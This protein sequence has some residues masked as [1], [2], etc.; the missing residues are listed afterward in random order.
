LQA[1]SRLQPA[2]QLKYSQMTQPSHIIRLQ[3]ITI[4]WMLLECGIALTASW[5]ARS[6]VLLAFG[7]DSFVEL[8]SAGVV[9]LQFSP[10]FRLNVARAAWWSG[11]LL[12]LLAGLVTGTSLAALVFGVQPGTSWSGIAITSAALIV[13]PLL[14]RAKRRAAYAINNRALAADA[15]QSA[16]CA[17][18]AAI[19]LIGLAA[20]AVFGIRWIDPLAALIAVPFIGIEAKRALQ[21][22]P[23]ECC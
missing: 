14:S 10:R 15:V 8:L 1:R 9:L 21:G 7:S 18:L 13:M 12:L 16:T 5:R 17:Y 23:C 6:S 11:I 22:E 3:L 19:S 2:T 20:T 4:L